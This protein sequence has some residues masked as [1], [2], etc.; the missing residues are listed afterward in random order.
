M[1]TR[2]LFAIVGIIVLILGG[3]TVEEAFAALD[4]PVTNGVVLDS[5]VEVAEGTNKRDV[6]KRYEAFISYTYDVHGETYFSE[7]ISLG[8]ISYRSLF[9]SSYSSAVELVEKFETGSVV[10]VSYDPSS[11][12]KSLLDTTIGFRILLIPIIA[13]GIIGFSLHGIFTS[14]RR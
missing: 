7:T 3:R 8:V 5:F 12:D 9:H 6:D 11:P 14:L 4:W 10:E 13:I 1:L 2:V